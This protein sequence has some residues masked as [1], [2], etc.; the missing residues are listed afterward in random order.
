[1]TQSITTLQHARQAL[2]RSIGQAAFVYG[3]PLTETYRTCAPAARPA[4][5]CAR[6]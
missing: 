3:Y 1:M 4:R 2:A 5:M 6:P